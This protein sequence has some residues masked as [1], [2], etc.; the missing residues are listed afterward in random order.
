MDVPIE[1]DLPATRWMPSESRGVSPVW[2]DHRLDVLGLRK[3]P[4]RRAS[5]ILTRGACL[6][7]VPDSAETSEIGGLHS[8]L[9]GRRKALA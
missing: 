3:T 7:N 1:V 4:G 5:P 9:D 8:P 2:A 6:A